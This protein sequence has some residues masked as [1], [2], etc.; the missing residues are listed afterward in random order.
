MLKIQFIHSS[1]SQRI[2]KALRRETQIG[3]VFVCGA[4]EQGEL[5]FDPA[6]G[7]FCPKCGARV[8]EVIRESSRRYA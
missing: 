7:Q 8:E 6:T 3:T 2:F 4:C 1:H 5:G